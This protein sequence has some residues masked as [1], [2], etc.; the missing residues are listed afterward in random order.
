M[1]SSEWHAGLARPGPRRGPALDSRYVIASGAPAGLQGNA[2]GAGVSAPTVS[3]AA[4]VPTAGSGEADSKA[5]FC[6][7]MTVARPILKIVAEGT[8]SML[9]IVD[10]SQCD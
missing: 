9:R 3:G 2:E 6:R 5:A 7:A 1:G 4:S 10:A 8:P